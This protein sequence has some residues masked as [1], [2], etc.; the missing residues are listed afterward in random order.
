MI[1]VPLGIITGWYEKADLVIKPIFDLL[2]TIPPIGWIPLMIIWFGIGIQAKAGIVFLASFIPCVINTYS[3]IKQTRSVHIWVV[4]T[5]GATRLQTLFY[6]AIPT[7]M[8]MI[9]T[10]L[11]LSLNT[12]WAALVAAELLGAVSGLGY[13]IQMARMTVRPDI[14]I[15]GMLT[16]G[17][18]G[19]ILSNLLDY[20][21]D[22]LVKGGR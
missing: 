17:A 10:G 13:M 22:H 9:F 3:G 14:I 8:P 18:I 2:R 12:A 7:A 21:E 6:V 19:M 16:I 5:F 4:Q 11:K 20:A 15:V 1:G